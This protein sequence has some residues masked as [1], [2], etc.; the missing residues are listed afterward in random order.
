MTRSLPISYLTKVV[1]Y[2]K[3]KGAITN[4]QCRELLDVNYD[5]SIKIFN[6]LCLIGALK[7][8]GAASTTKYVISDKPGTDAEKTSTAEGSHRNY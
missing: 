1:D 2:V 8:T 6:A 3:K 5:E 4:K 7:R